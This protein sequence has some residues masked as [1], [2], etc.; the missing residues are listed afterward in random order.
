L[1]LVFNPSNLDFPHLDGARLHLDAIMRELL[2]N[3][4]P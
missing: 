3:S 1:S 2:S 4:S